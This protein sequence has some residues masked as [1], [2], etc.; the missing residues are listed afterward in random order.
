MPSWRQRAPG[1]FSSATSSS[2]RV[3][4]FKNVPV[5]WARQTQSISRRGRP[6]LLVLLRLGQRLGVNDPFPI[7]VTSPKL[8]G[9]R[10]E[11]QDRIVVLPWDNQLVGVAGGCRWLPSQ[12]TAVQPPA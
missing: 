1:R 7:T 6:A 10:V 8:A 2:W 5:L 4:R 12:A 3:L 9:A 11:Q